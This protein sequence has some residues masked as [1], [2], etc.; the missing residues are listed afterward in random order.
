MVATRN[1]VPY[2]RRVFS[3]GTWNVAR[4]VLAVWTDGGLGRHVHVEAARGEN[5]RQ[6]AVVSERL[7]C[8]GRVPGCALMGRCLTNRMIRIFQEARAMAHKEQ[9]I[10]RLRPFNSKSMILCVLRSLQG[11]G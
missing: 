7:I 5:G 4:A 2:R 8:F 10:P 11:R 1:A 9:V 3:S 6:R